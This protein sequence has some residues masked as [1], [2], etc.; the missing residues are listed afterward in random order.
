MIEKVKKYWL[1]YTIAI[2]VGVFLCLTYLQTHEFAVA[3]TLKDRYRLLCDAFTIPG[4]L[5]LLSGLLMFCT[6]Q[7]ALDG[8][9][10]SMGM[11]LRAIIPFSK[12]NNE[13]YYEY[14]ERKNQKRVRGYSFLFV[15]GA[16]FAV[17]AAVFFV[18]FYS[19]Q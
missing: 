12:L 4:A 3:E 15:C 11:F 5:L 7:G 16:L 6:G 2:A 13:K 18:L 14:V 17:V 10:Y 1:R 9:T 19:V 8:I